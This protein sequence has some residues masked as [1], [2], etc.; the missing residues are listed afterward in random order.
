MK[1]EKAECC[2]LISSCDAYADLW[3]P[4]FTLFWKF[5][6]DCPYPVYLSTNCREFRHPRVTTLT[7]GPEPIWT[8]RLRRQLETLDAFY[9]LLCLED[10]FFRAPVPTADVEDC[11]HMLSGLQGHMMRLVC[12][13]GPDR[14]VSGYA[15]IGS[16]DPGAPYRVSTQAAIWNRQSLLALI[17]SGESI[18]DFEIRGSERSRE[19]VT[20]FYGVRRNVLTYGHHVVERGKWFPWEAWKFRRADIGCDFTSRPVMTAREAARWCALKARAQALDTIPWRQRLP[21]IQAVRGRK[22][23]LRP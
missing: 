4:F 3:Q 12:R 14:R 10:F 6:P 22:G 9:V 1:N 8:N 17:R 7:A 23:R 19:Y 21:L 20:G 5:W 15:G 18:W 2:I 13:P 16:I 11:L